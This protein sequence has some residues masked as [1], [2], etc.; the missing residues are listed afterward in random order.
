MLARWTQRFRGTRGSPSKPSPESAVNGASQ[1]G[2]TQ[3]ADEEAEARARKAAAERHRREVMLHTP[4]RQRWCAAVKPRGQAFKEI[5]A[6]F[7]EKLEERDTTA[8]DILDRYFTKHE[9]DLMIP[10]DKR[11]NRALARIQRRNRVRYKMLMR[12]QRFAPWAEQATALKVKLA[13]LWFGLPVAPVEFD[14]EDEWESGSDTADDMAE[15]ETEKRREEAAKR[16]DSLRF[17]NSYG[18]RYFGA[19]RLR[20]EW[21]F[22]DMLALTCVNSVTDRKPEPDPTYE[23]YY[24]FNHLYPVA[25]K[26]RRTPADREPVFISLRG[27]GLSDDLLDVD[28][29]DFNESDLDVESLSDTGGSDRDRAGEDI[30]STQPASI[31]LRGGAADMSHPLLKKAMEISDKLY[32]PQK[33]SSRPSVRFQPIFFPAAG[34]VVGEANNTDTGTEEGK[35]KG[36]EPAHG[37]SAESNLSLKPASPGPQPPSRG[38]HGR[39]MREVAYA[40]PP[41]V[42]TENRIPQNA[43][44]LEKVLGF[45]SDNL[46]SISLGVLTPT[47]QRKL[48]VSYYEMRNILLERSQECPYRGCDRVISL[49]EE[50]RMQQHLAEAHMG[51]KCNFCDEVLFQHWTVN[52]RRAH[53]LN[54]HCDLFL[55]MGHVQDDSKFSAGPRPHGQVD[56]DR[57]SRYTYCP[58][59]GRDH[60]TLDAKADREHHDK[61]CYPG[62]PKGEWMVCYK[63]GAIHSRMKRHK[64]RKEVNTLEW[65]YCERCG[66]GTGLFSDLYRGKHQ[67]YCMGFRTEDVRRCPWCQQDLEEGIFTHRRLSHVHFCDHKPDPEAQGP[68]DPATGEPWPYK[69]P[70]EEAEVEPE[71]EPPQLC[72]VCEKT[73]VHLDAHMLLKHIEA[74]HPEK[75]ALC[76]FCKLDYDKR[77]WTGDR[78]KILLHLDDHIHDRKVR[79]ASDLVQTL[80]Q[81]PWNHPY[82]QRALRPKDY[83]AVKD[84]RELERTK[85]L[86]DALYATSLKQAEEIKADKRQIALVREEL[87]EKDMK[88]AEA[89]NALQIWRAKGEGTPTEP[90]PTAA[91]NPFAPA[92]AAPATGQ[93]KENLKPTPG[94]NPVVG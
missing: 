86:Y 8:Q 72:P 77:G 57:E 85:Q 62:A 51:D 56:Y 5:V 28:L 9:R 44:P 90:A 34:V 30:V 61:V 39:E 19:D 69:P 33:D 14:A 58:R 67:L 3:Q 48:Q 80:P 42:H 12:S 89:E 76:L 66:L 25:S 87:R 43:P 29:D 93:K 73:I 40:H 55:N 4:P 35:G 20:S 36:K 59:C 75:T 52:Q 78:K 88:L 37:V 46:P 26:K 11:H 68:L 24:A 81:L 71:Q 92:A 45:G 32:A 16:A 83:A 2:S 84:A 91:A 79:L 49:A 74:N 22:P 1:R 38:E 63:C 50:G 70:L 18:Q 31:S 27:G 60:T 10:A 23:A 15:A 7:E 17:L 21:S 82:Q 64:C 47:E 53:F 13:M 94:R 65:P 6:I 41:S 54:R